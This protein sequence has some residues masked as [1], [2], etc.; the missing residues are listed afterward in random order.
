MMVQRLVEA[1]RNLEHRVN[2][3]SYGSFIIRERKI[4][5]LSCKRKK[6]GRK[7]EEYL[8]NNAIKPKQGLK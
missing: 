4:Q 8:V 1:L 2:R 3:F 7:K 5:L 6:F